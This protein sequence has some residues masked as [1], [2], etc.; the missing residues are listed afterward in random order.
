MTGQRVDLGMVATV[1]MADIKV[2]LTTERA[3]PFDTLHLRCAGI[4]PELEHIVSLKCGSNWRVAFGD[5][6]AAQ[7]YVDTPGICTS[8]IERMPLTRLRGSYFPLP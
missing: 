6:A 5:M 8:S 1:T 4:L 3:M 7:S 2:V